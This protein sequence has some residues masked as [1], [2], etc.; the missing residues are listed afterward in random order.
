MSALITSFHLLKD[1]CPDVQPF[2]VVFHLK[3]NLY[4]YGDS[5]QAHLIGLQVSYSF[6]VNEDM[7]LEAIQFSS[8]YHPR[9]LPSFSRM[10]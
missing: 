9:I 7:E 4:S 10:H 1:F 3:N 8:L 6:V 5:I 2:F